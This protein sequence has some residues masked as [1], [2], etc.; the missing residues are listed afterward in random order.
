MGSRRGTSCLVDVSLE[1]ENS[2]GGVLYSCLVQFVSLLRA[3]VYSSGE[4]NIR[5]CAV[6]WTDVA[7]KACGCLQ[8]QLE[9]PP[10][11][12]DSKETFQTLCCILSFMNQND[13]SAGIRQH[14]GFFLGG[15]R[16]SLGVHARKSRN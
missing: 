3:T 7:E 13:C 14:C 5:T 15:D 9:L 8:T 6:N 4:G 12:L 2:F 1:K 10:R 16:V 11:H